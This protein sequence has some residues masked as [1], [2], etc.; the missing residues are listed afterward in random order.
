VLFSVIVPTFGRPGEVRELLSGFAEQKS[1]DFEVIIV[2]G[3]P[4][5]H[6]KDIVEGFKGRINILYIYEKGMGISD[7]RNL[8]AEKARG[9]YLVFMDSDCIA[10]TDYFKTISSFLAVNRVDGFTGPDKAHPSFSRVQK[11]INYAMTSHFTTGGIR[12][13]RIHVGNIHLRG[14]NMGISKEAFSK[15]G[16]FS[17]LKVG[18][19]IDISLRFQHAGYTAALIHEAFVYHKRKTDFHKFF[20]QLF[21]HGKARI[22]LFKRHSRSLKPIYFLPSVFVLYIMAGFA[23]IFFCNCC[24]FVFL[25]TILLYCLLVL[26]DASIKTRSIPVGLLSVYGSIIMLIAYG[27]GFIYNFGRRVILRSRKESIRPTIIKE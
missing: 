12:G 7:S 25:L 10:A 21:L 3:S 16:G 26:T 24:F 14:F 23:A 5:N 15:I 2:D 22:D 18:E 20:V 17:G 4:D 9:D 11:A 6:L 8:G 13:Q 1:A 27:S 19:D